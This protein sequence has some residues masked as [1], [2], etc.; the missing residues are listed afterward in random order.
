LSIL[1]KTLP[2]IVHSCEKQLSSKKSGERT[3]ASALSLLS[4][5]CQSPFG[6]G[7]SEQIA[8]VVRQVQVL[9]KDPD[10]SKAIKLEALRLVRMILTYP[11]NSAEDVLATLSDL[12]PEL[13][14][15]A[16]EE[17]YKI[18]AEALRILAKLPDLILVSCDI[19]GTG[20]T[21]SPEIVASS[22][23]AAI[24]NRLKA[25]DLDQEIKEC[26]LLAA[27]SLIRNF[28]ESLPQQNCEALL[29]VILE[30]LK[31][32]ITRL[33]ALKTLSIIASPPTRPGQTQV[34]LTSIL[35][36]TVGELSSLLRQQSRTLK[37]HVL[38]SLKVL[39]IGYGGN[40]NSDSYEQILK[41]T[42]GIISDSDIHVSHLG[43]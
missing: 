14:R 29:Y 2:S 35:P 25:H 7:G 1:K 30:R 37:Q 43:L 12:L 33:S 17:W 16:Q 26:S 18:T 3:K 22:M 24:E 28:H 41:E 13:C 42:G 10:E 11:E 15:A 9:L 32:E 40:L 6:L 5:T 20:G 21:L 8:S 19:Q 38:D 27:A 39:I 4:A 23:Y 31:N 34:D 36:D